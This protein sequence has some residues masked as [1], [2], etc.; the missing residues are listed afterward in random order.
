MSKT[1]TSACW[2]RAAASTRSDSVL[3]MIRTSTSEY[4]ESIRRDETGANL[5]TVYAIPG[6]TMAEP[7]QRKTLQGKADSIT[8][9]LPEKDYDIFLFPCSKLHGSRKMW[10]TKAAANSGASPVGSLADWVFPENPHARPGQACQRRHRIAST[11][12]VY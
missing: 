5:F 12:N 8:K 10:E 2:N 1:S 6:P 3:V 4:L 11:M 7:V 9:K